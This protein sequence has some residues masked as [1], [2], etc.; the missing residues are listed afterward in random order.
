MKL[1]IK[2]TIEKFKERWLPQTIPVAEA[3]FSRFIAGESSEEL[4]Q[5]YG[6]PVFKVESA[7]RFFALKRSGNRHARELY[8][9]WQRRRFQ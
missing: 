2:T 5:D 3:I 8:D 9:D 7:I 1:H 6:V 4:Q